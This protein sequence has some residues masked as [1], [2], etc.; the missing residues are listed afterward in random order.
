MSN[1]GQSEEKERK[2]RDLCLYLNFCFSVSVVG[3][4]SGT[5]P[6]EHNVQFT[7]L[8]CLFPNCEMPSDPETTLPPEGRADPFQLWQESVWEHDSEVNQWKASKYDM[9]GQGPPSEEG[10]DVLIE[11]GI[12][13]HNYSVTNIRFI[14]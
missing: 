11:T 7:A 5:D 14:L 3:K 6:S 9:S 2:I 13:I 12:Y 4:S 8:R 1:L 10:V